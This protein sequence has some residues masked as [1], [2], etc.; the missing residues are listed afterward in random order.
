MT[1]VGSARGFDFHCHVDL[2]RDPPAFIGRCDKERIVTLA[3]TTTPKAWSQN[4]SW[5]KQSNYVLPAL[6]LHPELVATRHNEFELFKAALDETR[7]IGEVGLDGSGE[8]RKS[9]SLQQEIFRSILDSAQRL[10]G[11]VVTIHSRWAASEVL[12]LIAKHA[13]NDRVLCILHWF[14]GS[15]SLAKRAAGLG[16]YFSVN[17]AMLANERGRALVKSLPTSRLLTETDSPFITTGTRPSAPWDVVSTAES[18]AN[19]RGVSSQQ[20]SDVLNDNARRVLAFAD[21]QIRS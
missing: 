19:I 11:R 14:S 4:R 1:I 13:T 8:H 21:V 18:L 12:E 2:A 20:I 7:F 9:L 6:G 5:A 16:C 15:L 3:V 10:G 17:G